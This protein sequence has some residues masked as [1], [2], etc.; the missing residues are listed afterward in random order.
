MNL[1]NPIIQQIISVASK[2][3]PDAELFLFGSQARG[4]SNKSSDWDILILLNQDSVSPLTEKSF[5]NDFYDLELSTGEIFSPL[6]YS[7]KDW[8]SKYSNT[9]LYLLINKEGVRLK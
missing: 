4:N 8:N 7:K 1:K 2:S 5:M 6:V 9:P 3:A